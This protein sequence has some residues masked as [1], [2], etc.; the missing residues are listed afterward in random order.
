MKRDRLLLLFFVATWLVAGLLEPFAPS[1]GRE[2]HNEVSLVHT[3]V[4]AVVLFAWCRA[5]AVTHGVELPK[6]ARL[7]VALLPP[8][9]LP[10]Y[11]FRA[12]PARVA[13]TKTAKAVPVLG[14]CALLLAVG[15]YAGS[16]LAA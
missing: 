9:G 11:F 14:A 4:L 5:H 6:G 8:V 16:R 7:L 3:F 2:F 1:Y 15:T 13:A 12:F 10:Y